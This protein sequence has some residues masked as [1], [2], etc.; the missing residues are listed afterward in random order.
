MSDIYRPMRRQAPEDRRELVAEWRLERRE[1]LGALFEAAY[2]EEGSMEQLAGLAETLAD[3]IGERVYAADARRALTAARDQ[4]IA[5]VIEQEEIAGELDD[6]IAAKA[7]DQR[8]AA[9]QIDR[10]EREMD[11]ERDEE[12]MRG[13]AA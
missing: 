4:A 1:A 7:L 9:Y 12:W 2:G 10:V 3:E 8:E 13:G 6:W 5:E 11:R